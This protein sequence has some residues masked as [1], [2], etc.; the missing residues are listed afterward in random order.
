LTWQALG[1][2]G[3]DF[4]RHFSLALGYRALSTYQPEGKNL[5]LLMHGAFLALDFHW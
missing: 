2:I 1:T 3:Y 5:D 4:T